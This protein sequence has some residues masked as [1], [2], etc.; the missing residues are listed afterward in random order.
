MLRIAT[1]TGMRSARRGDQLLRGHL[2]A[3]VAVDRPHHAVG[4]ADLGADRGRHR[5]AHRAEAAR[6]HPRVG[7][8]E[9]PVLAGPHLV[10]ADARTRRSCRRACSRAGA[11]GR[12][13]GLSGSP[14]LGRLVGERVLLLPAADRGLPRR[15][16]RAASTPPSSSVADRLDQL[17]DHQPAVAGDA[18]VGPADLAEL[19]R[20][21]VDV[22][23]L[24][25]GRERRRPCR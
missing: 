22:D 8:V 19:G 3:A 13:C 12:I 4:P 1:L 7:V 18:D 6:V 24:G 5:E 25:V 21:D 20:V 2:E 10:L 14:V 23:D 11:R 9:L 16:G 17:L 15:S